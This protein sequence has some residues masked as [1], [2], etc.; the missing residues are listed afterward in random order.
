MAARLGRRGLGMAVTGHPVDQGIDPEA[1]LVLGRFG[2]R[3]GRPVVEAVRCLPHRRFQTADGLGRGRAR[4]RRLRPEVRGHVAAARLEGR[5]LLRRVGRGRQVVVHQ[6]MRRGDRLR[7]EIVEQRRLLDPRLGGLRHGGGAARH[8]RLARHMAHGLRHLGRDMAGQRLGQAAARHRDFLRLGRGVDAGGDHRDADDAGH[9]G[10]EGRAD[11]DVGVGVDFL[12][13][14]VG[15]LVEFE[16][17]QV[18]AAGDVD[19]HALGALQADLVQQ[20]VG[21]RL[22][23]GLQR[24]GLALA[25]AGAHHCLAHLVHH[26]ADV[27]EVG[28]I[29]PGRTMRSVTPLTP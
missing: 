11:D 14:P 1:G 4:G 18:V 29:R 2:P 28:L 16:Q 23:G 21:D 5:G 12:A 8:G 10:V 17:G 3:R 9:L 27:G 6:R 24:A 22:L 19:Q 26:R 7:V 20:R 15:G 13:N 25:L